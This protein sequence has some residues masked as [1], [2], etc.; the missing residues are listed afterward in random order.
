M[1][2]AADDAVSADFALESL[3][4]SL[5]RTFLQ[6]LAIQIQQPPS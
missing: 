1:T 2:S 5:M 6:L 3:V 4:V